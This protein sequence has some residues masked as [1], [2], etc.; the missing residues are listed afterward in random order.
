MKKSI[1]LRDKKISRKL[2]H[3]SMIKGKIHHRLENEIKSHPRH[4]I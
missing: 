2:Q 3:K 1:R 4:K